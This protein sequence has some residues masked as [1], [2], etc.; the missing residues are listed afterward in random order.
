MTLDV[1]GISGFNYDFNALTEDD[2]QSSELG[3]AFNVVFGNPEVK[4]F[5]AWPFF[6]SRIPTLRVL[7]S[8]H[9]L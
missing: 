8:I 7:V 5:K 2:G 9:P 1:I 4:S 3:N 6:Q